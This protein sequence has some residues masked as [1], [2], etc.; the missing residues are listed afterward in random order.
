MFDWEDQD[1]HG[2]QG[3]PRRRK[4]RALKL[5]VAMLLLA[6]AVGA[7]GF[8]YYRWCQSS[9][10]SGTPVSITIPQGATGGDVVS[11]LHDHG[12]IRCGL[13][14]RIVLRSRDQTFQAGT[15]RLRT[16]MSLDD[17]LEALASGPAPPPSL[18]MTI[19]PGWRLTQIAARV[20]DTLHLSEGAFLDAA[21]SG[22]TASTVIERLLQEFKSEAAGLPWNDADKLGMSDYD[23]VTIA[24]MIEREA[25]VPGDRAKIA[26]VIYNRL[27]VNMPL[28]IDATLLYADPTPGDNSLSD[29]DLHSN[30]PYNTRV[31]TGLP[32]T[33]IA[34]P[35]LD[36]LRAAL[37]PANVNYLYYVLCSSKGAHAFTSS[38][39]ECLRLKARC[40]G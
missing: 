17:A 4:S 5:L 12:V 34:S 32:P 2:A 26:A 18:R 24:S 40:L 16:D 22:N 31:H 35:G 15:Y 7:A 37:E 23:V 3:P 27:K 33:P 21:N 8:T 36:S 13:V 11:L 9:D 30:S 1:A 14:S 19:P 38:Y 20:H 39:S 10:G 25:R 28:G 29:S 6:L